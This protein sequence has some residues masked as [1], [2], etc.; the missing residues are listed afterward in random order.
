MT[1]SVHVI[2]PGGKCPVCG[3]RKYL[4][5]LLILATTEFGQRCDSR[6][7]Q[8]S[9]SAICE[10]NSVSIHQRLMW[11]FSSGHVAANICVPQWWE[12][13][14][15]R[16]TASD[17]WDE[18]EI[19]SSASDFYADAAKT[20][21]FRENGKPYETRNKHSLLEAGDTRG[22]NRFYFAVPR[23]LFPTLKFP[24]WAGILTFN[25]TN[26]KYGPGFSIHQERPSPTL[27]RESNG[28][29]VRAH[30]LNSIYHRFSRQLV[31]CL[32]MN[33]DGEGI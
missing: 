17:R 11:W 24:E 30:L 18:I 23:D 12:A 13:D 20:K 7:I 9:E 27:H 16:V 10:G 32:Q 2:T 8:W 29:I 1:E 21:W 25:P 6:I 26:T 22:P 28:A 5:L 4:E 19:K 3:R 33:L 15:V 14:V 31:G